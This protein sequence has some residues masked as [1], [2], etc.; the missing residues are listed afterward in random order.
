ML[1]QGIKN[2]YI[3]ILMEVRINKYIFSIYKYFSGTT[4]KTFDNNNLWQRHPDEPTALHEAAEGVDT[5]PDTA[6]GGDHVTRDLGRG[7]AN[8]E[9]SGAADK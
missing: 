7:A 5:A 1:Q 2:P 6:G 4:S 8:Q 3:K 9:N